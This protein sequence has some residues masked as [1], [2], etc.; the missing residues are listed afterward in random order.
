MLSEE[1]DQTSLKFQPIG[2][3]FDPEAREGESCAKHTA[4]HLFHFWDRWGH[5][6]QPTQNTRIVGIRPIEERPTHMGAEDAR[7]LVP[8]ERANISVVL[9]NAPSEVSLTDVCTDTH[10]AL[11]CF[12][13]CSLG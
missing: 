11:G 8:T 2:R 3:S 6:F 4:H 9:A 1:C 13:L 12:S 5:V 10:D 7:I